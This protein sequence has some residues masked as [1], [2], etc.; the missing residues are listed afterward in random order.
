MQASRDLSKLLQ[1]LKHETAHQYTVELLRA[2]IVKHRKGLLDD[3]EAIF[4]QKQGELRECN[5]LY[6]TLTG[7]DPDEI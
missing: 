1:E 2:R 4:R 6:K 7:L 3:S 5:Y